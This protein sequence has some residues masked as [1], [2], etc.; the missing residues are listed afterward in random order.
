[1]DR[2]GE[3]MW[4]YTALRDTRSMNSNQH[5][6]QTILKTDFALKCSWKQSFTFKKKIK[7]LMLIRNK[8]ALCLGVEKP[9]SSELLCSE[10]DIPLIKIYLW[11][12]QSGDTGDFTI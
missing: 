7:F 8:N 11:L 2:N 10:D 3:M 1:M 6:G 9:Q 4:N 5:H 12:L